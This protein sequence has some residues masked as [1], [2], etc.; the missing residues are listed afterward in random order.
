MKS[1]SPPKVQ[2]R[3]HTNTSSSFFLGVPI[4]STASTSTGLQANPNSS[5][6]KKILY[7]V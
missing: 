7:S 1:I 3:Y 5:H 6:K 4:T 2:I